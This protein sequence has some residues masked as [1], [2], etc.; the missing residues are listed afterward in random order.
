MNGRMAAVK[1]QSLKVKNERRKGRRGEVK[2]ERK[3]KLRKEKGG[4]FAS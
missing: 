1:A 4:G 2:D 3:G